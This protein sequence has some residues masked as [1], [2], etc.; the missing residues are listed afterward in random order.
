MTSQSM[1]NLIKPEVV[2][3]M[4][5][6]NFIRRRQCEQFSLKDLPETRPL[7]RFL[8]YYRTPKIE[9]KTTRNRAEVFELDFKDKCLSNFIDNCCADDSPVPNV[10][11]YVWYGDKELGYYNFISLMSVLR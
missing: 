2:S 4:A 7:I 1:E 6:W 11:H 8:C 5:D 3:N 9:V 10:V